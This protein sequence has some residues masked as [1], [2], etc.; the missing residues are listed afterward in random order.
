MFSIDDYFNKGFTLLEI[1]TD[2]YNDLYSL[3]QSENYIHDE[4]RKDKKNI[5]SPEWDCELPFRNIDY[6]EN[7]LKYSEIISQLIENRN[8]FNFWKLVYGKFDNYSIMI[9]KLLRNEFMPWHWDGFDSTF[10][11]ILIYFGD[12]PNGT[13][14]VGKLDRCTT[15]FNREM[16]HYYPEKHFDAI[17]EDAK[18]ENIFEIEP[19]PN[20]VIIMNNL[21]PLFVHHITEIQKDTPRYTLMCGCGFENNISQN[22]FTYNTELYLH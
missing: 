5:F 11:Q 8:E 2:I 10:I 17:S 9:N 19:Q 4:T 13:F 18:F 14:K 16:P 21:N 22:E 7:S 12:L 20:Q 1:N 15:T 6:Y 3:L